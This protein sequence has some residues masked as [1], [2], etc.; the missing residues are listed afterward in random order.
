MQPYLL[1]IGSLYIHTYGVVLVIAFLAAIWFAGRAVRTWPPPLVVL[2][3]SEVA[4]WASV[5]MI[6]GLIG[7]RLFYVLQHWEVFIRHPLEIPAIWLGGLIWYG[8]FL[9]GVV[10]TWT[11]ARIKGRSLVRL[12]DQVIPF[13]AMGHAIGRMGCF[14]NGCC[15][16]KPTSAWFGLVFP[17][18]PDV[19]LVPTQ[20]FEAAALLGIYSVL[21]MLQS[22]RILSRPGTL[23]GVYLIAYAV[24][25][26]FLEFFR[27]NQPIVW[28]LWTIPQVVS[29]PVAVA[30]MWFLL[31]YRKHGS[32]V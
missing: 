30:G 3:P 1:R 8:G 7:G 9:G 5:T 6:G 14:L 17:Q 2:S 26:F 28:D 12:I 19:A 16:G 13:V 31:Q 20:L 27:A 25:R 11:Y 22:P 10:A 24:A 4:E 23:F 32:N 15:Y 18:Q 21:R 29:I